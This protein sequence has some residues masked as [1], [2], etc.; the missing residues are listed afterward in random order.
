MKVILTERINKL[1]NLGDTVPVKSG[2]AR[3]FL[4]PTGRALYA[5]PKNTIVFEAK[6]AELEKVQKEKLDTAQALADQLQGLSL[7]IESKSGEGGKLYGSVGTREIVKAVAT[8][9]IE[10]GKQQ[11]R[12]PSGAIR[13]I[14]EYEIDI[15]LFSDIDATVKVEIKPEA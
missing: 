9:D 13:E 11:V 10:I 5:T 3:N 2:Y 4:I 1:G 14:G 6:R 15:H 8:H 7:V 12:M